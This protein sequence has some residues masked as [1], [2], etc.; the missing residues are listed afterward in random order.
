MA[1]EEWAHNTKHEH[2]GEKYNN[3]SKTESGYVTKVDLE[4]IAKGPFDSFNAENKPP[5][6]AISRAYSEGYK[7][8][9]AKIEYE[10]KIG[11]LLPR[12]ELESAWSD[13][14]I[15]F[16]QKALG[17]PTRMAPQLHACE[18]PQE[19]EVLLKEKIMEALN[20]LSKFKLGK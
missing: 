5:D 16:R 6:L 18:S 14:L 19:I 8:L 17:I 12:E 9:Y 3:N 10:E 11:L 2:R 4:S 20:E 13:I 7:A 1:I 15:A